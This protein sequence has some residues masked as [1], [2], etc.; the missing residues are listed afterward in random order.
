MDGWM[1]LWHTF[2][3]VNQAEQNN[4]DSCEGLGE[5]EHTSLCMYLVSLRLNLAKGEEPKRLWCLLIQVEEL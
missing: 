5:Q 1:Q 4:L 3:K 2:A